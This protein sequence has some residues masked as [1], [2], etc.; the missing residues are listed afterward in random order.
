[1]NLK[2]FPS[3]NETILCK[4]NN[5]IV[6]LLTNVNYSSAENG[7]FMCKMF[8]LLNSV[9]FVLFLRFKEF[10]DIQ[11][12]VEFTLK[13]LGGVIRTYSQINFTIISLKVQGKNLSI[14]KYFC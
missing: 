8:Y 9:L 3:D 2:T 7:T 5:K 10:L 14:T 11:A 4:K 6:A 1:M 13:R 12:I